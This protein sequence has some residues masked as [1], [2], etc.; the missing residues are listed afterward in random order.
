MI[1]RDDMFPK[2]IRSDDESDKD[3]AD[4]QNTEETHSR[5]EMIQNDRER[6]REKKRDR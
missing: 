3:K 6:Q 2:W 1:W 5:D 4:E